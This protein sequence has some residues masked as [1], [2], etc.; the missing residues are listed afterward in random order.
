MHT[1]FWGAMAR[2]L[3]AYL[4]AG[5]MR[6]NRNLEESRGWSAAF[7]REAMEEAA[8]TDV[9]AIKTGFF[10]QLEASLFLFVISVSIMSAN[11][12]IHISICNIFNP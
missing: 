5:N 3:G 8:A 6:L 2:N 9:A 12:Y 11:Q 7:L 10:S 4:T 1:F